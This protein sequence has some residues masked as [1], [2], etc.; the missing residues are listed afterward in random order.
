MLVSLQTR[1]PN[2]QEGCQVLMIQV[3]IMLNLSLNTCSTNQIQRCLLMDHLNLTA[4]SIALLIQGTRL[5]GFSPPKRKNAVI[6]KRSLQPPTQV[7]HLE[8]DFTLNTSTCSDSEELVCSENNKE[9]CFTVYQL[10]NLQKTWKIF[11]NQ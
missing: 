1:P 4:L 2:S 11:T 9:S 10:K 7:D 5:M 8:N 6:L 3:R